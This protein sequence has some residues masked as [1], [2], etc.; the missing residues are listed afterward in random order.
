MHKI[1]IIHIQILPVL[2]GVQKAMLDI[3][4]R[5][6]PD[7]YD[8]FVICNSEGELT[9][10]LRKQEISYLIIP[11][12]RREINPYF[13]LRAFVKLFRLFKR[14]KYDIV[15][16]HSSKPGILGRFA[17]KAAGI[18]HIVHTVQGFAFHEHSARWHLLFFGFLEKL[19]GYATDKVI[20]VNQKDKKLALRLKLIAP[21][22][23]VLIRNGVDLSC[24]ENKNGKFDKSTLPGVGAQDR[25]VCMVAR[26]W[27]QKAPEYFI[28][29][30][31]LILD[32]FPR[33]KFLVIGD[34]P[35]KDAL[36]A[37]TKSLQ[38][39]RSVQ[40][41]GWRSDVNQILRVIDVF[42]LP[43]LWEGLPLSI[44]EAMAASKPVVASDIKGNN[45]LVEHGETGFL[46]PPR[47]H[48]QISDYVSKLLRDP[49]LAQTMGYN[50]YKRVK[51][52]YDI[53]IIAKK[54]DYLYKSF[55]SDNHFQGTLIKKS[56]QMQQFHL[57]T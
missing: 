40:F 53:N 15:H 49:G 45:E 26:L 22:K 21:E 34:G 6:N 33:T 29:A 30:V 27:K 50:G 9:K 32:K 31:P 13:D 7:I 48:Q 51:Q 57:N 2:S 47:N 41:L 37:L 54:I 35:L 18:K 10:E 11:E 20:F 42:V 12:L 14:E 5:L 56:Q 16:T 8:P 19:A 39:D 4:I 44:L 28:K 1:K 52:T 36:L 55:L 17:A 43:S 24:F 46:F 38:V 25:L 3:L 23:I